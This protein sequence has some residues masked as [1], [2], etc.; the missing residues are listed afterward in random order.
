MPRGQREERAFGIRHPDDRDALGQG[1][2]R[3]PALHDQHGGAPGDG[4]RQVSMPVVPCSDQGEERL[5]Y[6]PTLGVPRAYWTVLPAPAVWRLL[7]ESVV[8]TADTVDHTV[9]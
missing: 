8:V 2:G 9:A 3:V 5:P 1:P 7:A 6:D 4:V